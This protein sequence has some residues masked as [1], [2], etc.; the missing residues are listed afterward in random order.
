MTAVDLE[1]EF[2]R[3]INAAMPLRGPRRVQWGV[4]RV[5]FY[6]AGR[7]LYEPRTD[8]S[9]RAFV[10]PIVEGGT[11]I[12]L[13]AVDRWSGPVGTRLGF[14][15]ALGVDEIARARMGADLV[16]HDRPLAWLQDP[17]AAAFIFN[18]DEACA[19]LDGVPRISCTTATFARRLQAL[20]PPSQRSR[21]APPQREVARAA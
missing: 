4:A 7:E 9:S 1:A 2:W 8:G 13:A 15:R 16:V 12:D 5:E 20:F 17:R 18:L 3:A 21:I 14:G 19:L 6:G 11:L 10:L